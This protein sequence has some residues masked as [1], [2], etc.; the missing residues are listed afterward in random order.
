MITPI[1]Q[2]YRQ[3]TRFAVWLVGFYAAPLL[4]VVFTSV[5]AAAGF[6]YGY[7]RGHLPVIHP[8]ILEALVIGLAIIILI[9]I[10]MNDGF[11]KLGI[12]SFIPRVRF[13]NAMFDEGRLKIDRELK[14]YQKL[15]FYLTDYGKNRAFYGPFHVA[16]VLGTVLV[17]EYM[18]LH[19]GH[20]DIYLQAALVTLPI[21]V[22]F[23]Y[24]TADLHM[25]RYRSL[26]KR[27]LFFMGHEPPNEYSISL[28]LKFASILFVI[29]LSDYILISLLRSEV[30]KS[31]GGYAYIIGF[32][33]FSLALL[34][35]LTILLFSSIFASIKE[36]QL[37]AMSL[38]E[39]HDPDF[40]S[41]TSDQELAT[42]STGFF[43]AAQ[44]V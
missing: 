33:L 7:G 40:Y 6:A 5:F 41:Q 8:D 32:S 16:V 12:R 21:H 44:R 23:V 38:Q 25:G 20:G 4:H 19:T 11:H 30:A 22:L 28:K 14:E 13:V 18:F 1:L 9:E 43:N 24:V 2:F 15:L 34:M 35:A 39:G 37:A 27:Q 17:F 31:S 26:V 36:L 29:A 42:L 3:L 10:Y